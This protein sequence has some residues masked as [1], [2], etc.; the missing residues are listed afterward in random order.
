MPVFGGVFFLVIP[1]LEVVGQAKTDLE[2]KVG[3]VEWDG[4]ARGITH[5]TKNLG[6]LHLGTDFQVGVGWMRGGRRGSKGAG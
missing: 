3:T 5:F 2:V 1:G 4:V 6:D